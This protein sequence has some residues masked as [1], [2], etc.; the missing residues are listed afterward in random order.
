MVRLDHELVFEARRYITGANVHRVKKMIFAYEQ[1]VNR[2]AR[3]IA[4]KNLVAGIR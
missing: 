1:A 4:Q 3:E 2:F